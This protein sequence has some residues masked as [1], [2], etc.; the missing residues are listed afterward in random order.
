MSKSEHILSHYNP[1]VME[2]HR[3]LKLAQDTGASPDVIKS[4]ETALELVDLREKY[5]DSVT[6][7]ETE[8]FHKILTET[9]K[10]DWQSLHSDGK[11]KWNLRPKMMTG[12][13]EG[14]FLK[15]MVSIQNAKRVLDIGMFTGYSALSMAEALPADGEL[16]TVDLEEYLETFTGSLLRE[17]PHSK[18]IQISIGS[19]SDYMR[20]AVKAGKTFDL[21]FLDADKSYYLEFFKIIFEEGLLAP[22]G[23]VL[24]DNAFAHGSGY[25]PSAEENST[26]RVA[27]AVE[28]DQSLHKVMVPLR[29]GVLILRRK[30]D[31][32]GEV[33]Q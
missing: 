8:V 2:M 15:S 5:T 20:E 23:T 18:K 9:Y 33:P 19:P 21:I 17:S 30:T 3:A 24:V 11:T 25:K 27:S 6:S 32:V 1:A 10:H 14:Q 7:G 22:R 16:V 29:D 13:L 28:A 26:Q 12:N 31:V 4:I